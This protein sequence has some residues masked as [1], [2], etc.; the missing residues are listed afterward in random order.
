MGNKNKMELL[1]SA[2]RMGNLELVNQ[3][4]KEGA[5][6]NDVDEF[7]SDAL[8]YSVVSYNDNLV[9]YLVSKGA[10]INSSYKENR[11]ILHIAV[12]AECEDRGAF[13]IIKTLVNSGVDINAQDQHGNTPLWYAAIYFVINEN[14][15]KFLLKNGAD[16]SVINKYGSSVCSLA[17]DDLDAPLIKWIS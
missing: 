3:C 10:N 14:T 6:V 4:L 5:P 2:I 17:K 15:I 9:K 8:Y 13:E 16:P 12:R 1:H 11:N 7:K